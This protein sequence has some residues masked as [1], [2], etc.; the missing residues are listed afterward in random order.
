MC[1]NLSRVM[2]TARKEREEEPL[3]RPLIAVG[4]GPRKL[5]VGGKRRLEGVG[6][7][8]ASN[9]LTKAPGGEY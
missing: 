5:R 1:S 3:N 2:R 4:T 9:R 8:K 6:E 7:E